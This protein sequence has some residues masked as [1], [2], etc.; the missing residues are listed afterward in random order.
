MFETLIFNASS[1]VRREMLEGREHFVVP[2]AMIEEGVW[3]GNEGPLY[4]PKQVLTQN[5]SSWD[6]K[7][8]VVYHP[9]KGDNAISACTPEVLNTSKIGIVLNTKYDSKLRCEAWLDV[10]RTKEVDIRVYNA[11]INKQVMEVSTGMLLEAKKAVVQNG[12]PPEFNGKNYVGEVTTVS[13]DHLAILPD[14]TGAYSAKSGGG[15]L[16]TNAFSDYCQQLKHFLVLN[17]LSFDE[18]QRSLHEILKTK[19]GKPGESW[20]GWI[21][22]VF[23]DYVVVYNERNLWKISYTTKDNS[24]ALVGDPVKVTRVV[25]YTE[26]TMVTNSNGSVSVNKEQ[27]IAALIANSGVW[28]EEDRPMLNGLS[29]NKIKALSEPKK[30]P[31]PAPVVP[32]N[33]AVTLEQLVANADPDTRRAFEQMKEAAERERTEAITVINASPFNDFTEDVLKALD[34]GLLKGIAKIAAGT[35]PQVQQQQIH[36][37]G[38]DGRGRFSG[39][40]FK[41]QAGGHVQNLGQKKE[42]DGKGL[43]VP[44][45]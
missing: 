5:L 33:P 37:A 7:P 20:D 38:W 15:L 13:P 19:F 3:A 1:S 42:G 25:S 30:V 4:Y 8:V 29:E 32:A 43:V 23:S 31:T 18:I 22:E 44:E 36:N 40:L 16:V 27:M 2:V 11:I 12:V 39:P 14:Q 28:T 17:G 41:G 24:V 35:L 10:E 9:I 34:P 21:V 6:H 45:L 26:E